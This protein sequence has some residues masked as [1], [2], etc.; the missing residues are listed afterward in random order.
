[1]FV[2][3]K[4]IVVC[5]IRHIFLSDI[6]PPVMKNCSGDKYITTAAIEYLV[7]WQIPSF[8]DPHSF[9]I[10]VTSNYPSNEFTFPWGDF[11]VSYTAIKPTNGLSTNCLFSISLRRKYV[12]PFCSIFYDFL[13]NF[14]LKESM[15]LQMEKLRVQITN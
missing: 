3:F 9:A 13:I 1:M 15:R 11:K 5:M 8:T 14:N 12:L 4:V 6:Q 10:K 2:Q 7:K